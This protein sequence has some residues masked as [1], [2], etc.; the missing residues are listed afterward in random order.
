MKA[1]YL[2]IFFIIVSSTP[3][4]SFSY[5]EE[6]K[7]KEV[8]H[9][10]AKKTLLIIHANN[11]FWLDKWPII[12][13]KCKDYG[14]IS[15]K[16]ISKDNIEFFTKTLPKFNKDIEQ[17]YF[18]KYSQ[19]LGRNLSDLYTDES[20]GGS[21]IKEPLDI[22]FLDNSIAVDCNDKIEAIKFYYY[23]FTNK[24]HYPTLNWCERL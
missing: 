22:V 20:L 2:I 19:Q 12:K 11:N 16:P 6:Q 5:F 7:K 13:N 17:C 15:N 1:I 14:S 8:K 3:V 10:N 4:F 18:K 9:E 21:S 23:Y 24:L